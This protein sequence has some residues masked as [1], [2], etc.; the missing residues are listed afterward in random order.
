ML[1]SDLDAP[2]RVRSLDGVPSPRNLAPVVCVKKIAG[3]LEVVVAAET[4]GWEQP[5]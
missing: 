1:W 5:F 2:E 3:H 4:A